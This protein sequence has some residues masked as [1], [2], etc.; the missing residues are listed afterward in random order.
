MTTGDRIGEVSHFY[1]HLSVAVLHIEKSLKLGDLV[2]FLGAHTDFGQEINSMQIEHQPVTEA[3]GQDVAVLVRRRVRRG[4]AVYRVA[5]IA[6]DESAEW[7]GDLAPG[8]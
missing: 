8:R 2:H 5:E 1:N 7:F 6:E 3:A 4:D